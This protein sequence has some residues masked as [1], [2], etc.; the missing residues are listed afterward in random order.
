MQVS[1]KTG[2]K[3]SQLFDV[4]IDM[5][6]ESQKEENLLQNENTTRDKLGQQNM[7]SDKIELKPPT[8]K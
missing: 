4:V 1:A 3:I 5:I 7:V 6:N 2:K 8:F